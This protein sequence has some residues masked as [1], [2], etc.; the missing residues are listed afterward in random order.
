MVLRTTLTKDWLTETIISSPLGEF[1]LA[2]HYR[3]HPMAT[4][5]FGGGQPLVQT[6]T[7]DK[8]I[9]SN[10]LIPPVCALLNV[11]FSDPFRG[12]HHCKLKLSFVLK[13]TFLCVLLRGFTNVNSFDLLLPPT[14]FVFGRSSVQGRSDSRWQKISFRTVGLSSP[15]C[16]VF[17]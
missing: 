2:D 17:F 13:C 12:S 9:E 14:R 10:H 5:H 1:H 6:S 4:S 16:F 8:V 15:I 11:R 7:I 3:F